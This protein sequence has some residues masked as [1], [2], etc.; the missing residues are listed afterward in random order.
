MFLEAKSSVYLHGTVRTSGRGPTGGPGAASGAS[1]TGQGGSY[2]G[3][4][5]MLQ[6]EDDHYFSCFPNQVDLFVFLKSNESYIFTL[7]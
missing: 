4:G 6:C 2:G 7:R 1:E 5:G 3:S